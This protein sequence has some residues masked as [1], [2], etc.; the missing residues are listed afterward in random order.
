MM[1]WSMMFH[2]QRLLWLM[3]ATLSSA[4]M[5]K[6]MRPRD[7]ASISSTN[8]AVEYVTRLPEL[9]MVIITSKGLVANW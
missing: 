3:R 9:G 7:T 4:C 5:P 8:W 2:S 6:A 1:P